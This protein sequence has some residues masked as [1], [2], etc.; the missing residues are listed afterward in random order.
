MVSL[1]TT[2]HELCISQERGP[3][4]ITTAQLFQFWAKKLTHQRCAKILLTILPS[5]T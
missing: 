5:T 1:V 4:V 2:N 3:D